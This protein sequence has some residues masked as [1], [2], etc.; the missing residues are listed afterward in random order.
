MTRRRATLGVLAFVALGAAWWLLSDGLSAEERR[1]VG[2][3]R[4]C[5]AGEPTSYLMVLSSDR[6][7][8]SEVIGDDSSYYR[9]PFRWSARRGVV[10]FDPE[11]SQ[12]RRMLRPVAPHVGLRVAPQTSFAVEWRSPDVINVLGD[13]GSCEEWERVGEE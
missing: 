2:T 9:P 10:V 5:F 1:L 4:L 7:G 13:D 6:R 3:W 8:Q 11:P 12:V